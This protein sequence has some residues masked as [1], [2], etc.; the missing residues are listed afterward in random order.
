MTD[1]KESLEP[2]DND[3]VFR[4][5]CTSS[6]FDDE[7]V[8]L[9]DF[10]LDSLKEHPT[11]QWHRLVEDSGELTP[12][13]LKDCDGLLIELPSTLSAESL[14]GVER[15]RLVARYGVGYDNLDIS[16]CTD[17][18]VLV[19]TTPDGVRRP[20]AVAAVTLLLAMSQHLMQRHALTVEGRWEDRG[21]FL[22]VGLVGRTVGLVGFGN[23]GREVAELLRPFEPRTIVADPYVSA[24]DAA[25]SG[26]E[27]VALENMMREAD[28]V[29]VLCALTKDTFHLLSREMLEHMKGT[30]FLVNVA[31]GPIVDQEALVELLAANEI[32]GAG[33]DVFEEEPI[34]P[35]DPLLSFDNVIATGHSLGWTDQCLLDCGLSALQSAIDVAAGHVPRN[36][37]NREVL[38]HQ[39]LSSLSEPR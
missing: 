9:F 14:K 5:G 37:L 3:G 4:L 28:F 18:G 38:R 27:L 26:C 22:G 30:A 1:A 19:T 39:R 13:H 15:L 35:D 6:L 17:A 29:L 20:M 2:S 31:R 24:E 12:D 32:A 25:E 7:G 33:L 8:P 11:I 36:V 10:G 23:V 21:H 34:L 16:A